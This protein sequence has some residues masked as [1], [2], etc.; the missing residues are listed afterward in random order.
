MLVY[1]AI[2]L[3]EPTRAK[4]IYEGKLMKFLFKG[5]L[6]ESIYFTEL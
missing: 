3:R 1:S 4:F 2:D 5:S 6:L